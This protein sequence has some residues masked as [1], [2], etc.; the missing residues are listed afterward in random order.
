MFRFG[1]FLEKTVYAL[2]AYPLVA[3][4]TDKNV[5]SAAS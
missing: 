4:V 1:S 2:L 3:M 5:I